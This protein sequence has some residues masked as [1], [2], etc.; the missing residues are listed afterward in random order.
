[1]AV[2]TVTSMLLVICVIAT[3]VVVAVRVGQ[4]PQRR[5]NL[6]NAKAPVLQSVATVVDKR[7]EVRGTNSQYGGSTLTTYYVTFQLPDSQ[8]LELVVDGPASGQLVVGDTGQLAWQ[9]TWF[10]GFQR[11]ILR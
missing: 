2:I 1:M 6:A 7:E 4:A 3:I 11:Q 5:Q 10:R 8:R 9:G